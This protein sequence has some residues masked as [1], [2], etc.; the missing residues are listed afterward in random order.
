MTVER[1]RTKLLQAVQLLGAAKRRYY[2]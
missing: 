1:Q 2:S